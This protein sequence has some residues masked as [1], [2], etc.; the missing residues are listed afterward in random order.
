[1]PES[2]AGSKGDGIR[3][4]L[5]GKVRA[6]DVVDPTQ[7]VLGYLR[8]RL[9][10]TGTKEG[11]AEGDCGA[12]TVVVG[13]LAG[14]GVALHAVNACI[15]FVPT[16]D[17]KALFT[18]E[19]LRQPDGALHPAQQAMVDCHGSQCGF[20]TP[21]FV[22]S[23]WALYLEHQTRQ[24]RPTDGEIRSALTGNLCR[25]TGYRPIL[26]AAARMFDL[27]PASFDRAALRRQLLSI[28]R[29]RSLVHQH[30]G[31][32]FFAPR[33][34][35]ELT[36]LR[37]SHPRATILAGN[38]DIGLWVTKQLRELEEI[39]YIGCI[40]ELRAIRESDG[41]LDIGAG[42]TLTEAYRA[43]AR[44]YPEVGEMWERFASPPIRNAGTMGGNVANGSP[45]GD[46]MPGLI[47]LGAAVTLRSAKGSRRLPLEDL[48]IGYMKRAMAADEIVEGISVPLPK[49]ALRFR[50][51]KLSKRRDSDI[52]AVCA[53]FAIEL[54]G[55]RVER[56]RVAFGGLAAT[57]KRALATE[58]ALVGKNWTEATVRAAMAALE[59]DYTPLTDMRASAAYR[60]ATA[61]NLL[62]RFF[63]E[64]RPDNPL[65]A[66]AVSVFATA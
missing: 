53:A 54:A 9:G 64:T 33:S 5:D 61:G 59:T 62:Y 15:Q 38:T 50:T 44:H 18:V 48:Y 31:R 29:D 43:L 23:L 8:E 13:E 10:R 49:P 45:I 32:V 39:I 20:C 2:V 6:V 37:A 55:D 65:P 35:V 58:Q 1:M 56:C 14:D 21:G 27:A 57:P 16:L 4:I 41:A 28:Q 7:S 30:D 40:E 46:S 63:L 51:Y 22:M 17:G 52:S 34:T 60:A 26:D 25:C 19:D 47:A 11:C 3:F 24:T 42:A 12:C 66:A 36:T